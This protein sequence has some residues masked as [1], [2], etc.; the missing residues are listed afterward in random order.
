MR[1]LVDAQ[2]PR[3][4]C[5]WLKEQGH[6]VLH[7]L[8]LPKGN[9][10]PDSEIISIAADQ[11][12]VVITKDSDFV[13]SFFVAG[14]PTLLLL[15]TGNVSNVQLQALFKQNL[16]RIIAA[17]NGHRFVEITLSELVVHE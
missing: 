5:D 13:Q 15:S 8:D 4:L 6:D 12:R 1:F 9:R 3:L 10:T 11:A 7:T 17:F 16:P 2:L 14:Q